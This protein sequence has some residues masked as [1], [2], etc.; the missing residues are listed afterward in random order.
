[1]QNL[2]CMSPGHMQITLLKSYSRG[3]LGNNSMHVWHA[4]AWVQGESAA[5]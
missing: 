3:C 5:V 1:M 2:C 4:V